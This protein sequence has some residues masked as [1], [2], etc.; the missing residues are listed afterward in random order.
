MNKFFYAKLALTNIK[1]N[2]KTYIPYILTCIGTIVMFYIMVSISQNKGLDHISGG[3]SL[4]T[5]LNFG[6]IVIAIFSVIF[7][8]YTNSFLLKRRKKEIGLYNILGM[9][10]KHIAKVMVWE[11]FF[12]AVISVT[13]GLISGMIVS[14]LMF[15]LLLKLLHFHVPFGFFISWNSMLLTTGLFVFIFI[16]VLLNNFR[17]IHLAKPI[18]LINGGQMGETEPKT[19]WIITIVGTVCLGSGYYIAMTTESPLAALNLFFIAVLLVIIGTYA[20]FTAGTIALLK[21]LRKNKSF[22]YKTKNFISVSGMIYRMKQNAAGLA[23]ICILSTA[24]LVMISTTVSLYVGMEN[25][26]RTRFTRDITINANNISEK[27]TKEIQRMV[28]D[29][30]KSQNVNIKNLTEYRY[31]S[32]SMIQDGYTF[33]VA[34]HSKKINT[35]HMSD[36]LLIPLS[37]YNRME[38]RSASLAENEVL[39]FTYRGGIPGST[40]NIGGHPFHIKE[41]IKNLT[42]D[43]QA[44]AMLINTYCIIVPDTQ[45]IGNLYRTINENTQGKGDLSYY[46]GFDSDSTPKRQ[47]ALTQTLQNK[48]K[49][50][51]MEGNV[52]GIE[53]SRDSFY[54]LYG[55]LFFLG[56]Y[57]GALFIMATVLIIYYKQISEGFDD[58][59]RYEIMQKVGLTRDE[60]KGS[61][62]SQVLMVFFL[63]L[64][65]AVVNIAFAFKVITKL[66]A[67]FNLTDVSLFAIT[68]GV[69]ILIFAFLYAI[70]YSLTAREYYRIVR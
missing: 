28:M 50:F 12:I 11:M 31:M 20:L 32:F 55:G 9:E 15:L 18:E 43:G 69:T 68:T 21:L 19:K 24:V 7:L 65:M 66:L 27:A 34:N 10:K 60:I 48:L 37:E 35:A 2:G 22:Y 36:L 51:S 62:Q 41:H 61:I 53:Q 46:Y 49:E 57:L 39:L 23:S 26:L 45:T 40:V 33:S 25:V 1:K 38:N 56:L 14:K 54:S 17:Q 44:S 5:L 59:R 42:I 58:K 64:L 70:V 13:T 4:K 6:T 47:I 67:L 63:P 52:E 8:F 3:S 16:L 29:E 30:A